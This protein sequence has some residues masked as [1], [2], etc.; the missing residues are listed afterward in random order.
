MVALFDSAS[1]AE[2]QLKLVEFI[3]KVDAHQKVEFEAGEKP[4]KM[5]TSRLNVSPGK[6]QEKI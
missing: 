2:D 1:N 3:E 6:K 4:E 5:S